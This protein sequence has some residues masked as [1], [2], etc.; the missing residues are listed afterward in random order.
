MTS[1]R[2]AAS[3]RGLISVLAPVASCLLVAIGMAPA[4]SV[5]KGMAGPGS[6]QMTEDGPVLATPEGLTLYVYGRDRSSPGASQCNNTHYKE[7]RHVTGD[8]I[9]LPRPDVRKT[10]EDKWPPFRASVDASPT[11]EWSTIVRHDGSLQW[12]YAGQPLYQSIK[13]RRLG[14]VNGL[15]GARSEERGWQPAFAPLGFPPGVKLV[16]R[17]VGLVLAMEDGRLLYSRGARQRNCAHCLDNLQPLVGGALGKPVGDW[18]TVK[19]A[20][21]FKQYAYKKVPVFVAPYGPSE[22]EG[23]ALDGWDLVVY[24]RAAPTPPQIKTRFSLIGE[25]YTNEDGMALYVFTCQAP[26]DSQSCDDPGDPAAYWTVVCSTADVCAEHWR[27]FLA[28][29]R[30]RPSGE[31]TI[32]DVPHPVYSEPNGLTYQADNPNPVV[33]VWAYRG[34]PVY[35]F[36]DDDEPGQV[37]G[38][39]IRGYVQSAGFYA[40]AVPGNADP[41][42]SR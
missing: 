12:A 17:T 2:H 29:A 1:K 36:A 26:V 40:L 11:G 16:R 23:D 24:K 39:Q 32:M 8:F 34:R 6:V 42:L 3:V 14:E 15:S 18:S 13:D 5:A 20:D 22:S 25:I 37:L 33:R 28:D 27:P 30:A 38:H 4:T 41:L 31:W 9:Y 21:G 35:T 7:R 10:C 19:V